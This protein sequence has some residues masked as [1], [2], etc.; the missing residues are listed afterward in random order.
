MKQ[1]Q[2]YF[3]LDQMDCGSTCLRMIA[4]H[5]G[6][7]FNAHTMRE[8]AQVSKEGV[9]MLGIA[10]AA[11]SIGL[12]SVG[13]RIGI[14]KLIKDVP[15]PCV[16]HWDQVHFVVLYEIKSYSGLISRQAL[17]MIWGG[18]S[19][20]YQDG[21]D[22]VN[23]SSASSGRHQS[24]HI[25][26][27]RYVL[28]VADPS[29]GIHE[30]TVEEFCQHWIGTRNGRINEGIALIL[31][32][33]PQFY[34]QRDEV[35]TSLNLLH[36]FSYLSRYKKL[37][38][39]LFCGFLIGTGLSLLFP[40]ITQSVVDY[41]IGT[42]NLSFVYLVLFA[43]LALTLSTTAVDFIRGW[44]LLHISSRV[45][46][47][48]LSEFLSKL[49]RLPL[50][51]FDV[52][53]FG[54]IM[55]RIGDHGRI[56]SFLT[57]Q[58]LS[59]IFSIFNL[60]VYGFLLAYYSISIFLIAVFT[61]VI[62]ALWVSLF[63]R[64]RR[65]LDKKRF[66]LS[67]RS[68]SKLVQLIQ[69]MQDI[70]LGGA[71]MNKRWEWERI[72]A[73]L[74][75]WSIKTL[76]ISQYQQVGAVLI[77]NCKNVILTF[78]AA[79]AVVDGQLTLGGMMSIQYILAQFNAPI[80]MFVSLMQSWQGAQLSLERLNEI[81]DMK[82]EDEGSDARQHDFTLKHD[83]LIENLSFSYPG[84]GNDQTLSNINLKI[85]FGKVTAIVGASGSGKS[86][87]LK[88]LL[89]FYRPQSGG[90]YLSR[91]GPTNENLQHDGNWSKGSVLY[92]NTKISIDRISFKSW[93]QQCGVV[94][95]EGYIFSDSIAQN[96]A[97]SDEV[98]ES[99]RL[100]N[101]SQLANIHEFIDT[102][103]LGYHTRIGSEG[104]GIS[105]G[106]RQRI[107]IAR[108]VYKNPSL[109]L[110]DEATNSLDAN[111]E[112]VIVSNLK[113]FFFG[114]TVVVVA[115]RLSTVRSA[116]QIVVLNCGK[117]VEVGTHEELIAKDSHYLNLVRNQLELGS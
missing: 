6:R 55:Q 58:S 87:L 93:R 79:K 25:L 109:L 76:S 2:H 90:I 48:I 50:S 78:L 17:S 115:H 51:F 36:I 20:P 7:H 37:L 61:S 57:G 68:Q 52:K 108:A 12:K 45:N 67:S 33:T 100:F 23:L 91:V 16:I 31:E 59:M 83:I 110:F 65:E 43:Q 39:Q 29:S 42:R 38:F 105:Q 94:M 103:P 69:G 116:D 30:Y 22:Y 13:I 92:D 3:Q 15:L 14:E 26:N 75:K 40:F 1:F 47:S 89:R 18:R 85:P 95:Q 19:A 53:N 71:E 82:D 63:L 24:K 111:N 64:S 32:P 113:D 104:N 66:Q 96:I 41:G 98:I 21:N 9:S 62:Y 80:E 46:L 112:S 10:E 72:Q 114:R 84:V 81:H 60:F 88:L 35:P 70:K 44:I 106:Q 4:R 28:K 99:E 97:V 77:N 73:K 101:S 102:L 11:E 54:D 107:L 117:I 34:D 8:K 49:M 27:H 56:E 86:T 5:Y 74:F